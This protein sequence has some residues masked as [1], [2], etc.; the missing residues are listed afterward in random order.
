MWHTLTHTGYTLL[1]IFRENLSYTNCIFLVAGLHCE[2][3]VR[4]ITM[5]SDVSLRDTLQNCF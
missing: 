3:V 1:M 5:P 4:W 2:L